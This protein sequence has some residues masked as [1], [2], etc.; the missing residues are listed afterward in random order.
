VMAVLFPPSRAHSA[1]YELP[2]YG[3]FMD[4]F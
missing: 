1:L 4:A 3:L 2:E